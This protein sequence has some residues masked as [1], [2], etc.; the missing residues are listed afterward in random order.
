[1][2]DQCRPYTI[3]DIT[4]SSQL[5]LLMCPSFDYKYFPACPNIVASWKARRYQQLRSTDKKGPVI[6]TTLLLMQ[7]GDINRNPGPTNTSC[8]ICDKSVLS[9]HRATLCNKCNSWY[10]IDCMVMTTAEKESL[11]NRQVSWI[12]CHC[13]NPNV[14]SSIFSNS[15]IELPNSFSVL[16]TDDYTDSLSSPSATSSPYKQRNNNRSDIR[17]SLCDT[18]ENVA[19]EYVQATCAKRQSLKTLRFPSREKSPTLKLEML[20]KVTFRPFVLN[21][22]KDSGRR[23]RA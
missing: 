14:D 8:A 9:N 6:V 11:Q 22:R 10:H 23:S 19:T 3:S 20:I 2:L 13:S 1:M 18:G 21:H 12:C 4:L 15:S 17:T 5:S 16:S 7:A